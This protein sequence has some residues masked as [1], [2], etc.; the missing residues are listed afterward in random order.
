VSGTS[1]GACPASSSPHRSHIDYL[2]LSYVFYKH[3]IPLPF[4]AAGTN[5]MF[6]PLGHVFRKAGAFFHPRTF[7]GNVVY[8]QVMETYIRTMLREGY[9]IEFFIEGGRSRTGKMVMPKYGMLSMVI[10]ACTELH[11]DVALIPVFIGY[12]RVLEEKSYIQELGRPEGEGEG[13]LGHQEPQAPRQALRPR[14]PERGGADLHVRLP[15]VLRTGRG[16]TWEPTSGAVS[17]ARSATRSSA[18]S[19]ASP[20]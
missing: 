18:R 9:P 13:Q 6:W 17:T 12:D 7:G 14:L 15:A 8:R 4:I 2:L 5:L 11:R 16:R 20:W 10:Q 3:N 1:L 19:A